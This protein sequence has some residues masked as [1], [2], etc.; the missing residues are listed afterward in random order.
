MDV[1]VTER[2]IVENNRLMEEVKHLKKE[3]KEKERIIKKLCNGK[4]IFN[5]DEE[6]IEYR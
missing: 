5:E 3:L 6:R 4:M 2:L 1:N